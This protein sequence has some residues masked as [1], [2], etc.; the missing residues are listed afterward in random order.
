MSTQQT[1]VL[2]LLL[3]FSLICNA[4]GTSNGQPGDDFRQ[5][6]SHYMEKSDQAFRSAR[7]SQGS[8]RAS[9]QRIG[10]LYEELATIKRRAARL[11]DKGRWDEISWD[12]YH[13][14]NAELQQLKSTALTTAK[15]AKK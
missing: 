7:S 4:D 1:L 9:H 13:Q 6:A 8:A 12:R 11:A 2:G 5:T 10:Y 15:Q 3:G 14:L